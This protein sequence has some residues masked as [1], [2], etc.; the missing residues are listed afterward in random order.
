MAELGSRWA[1]DIEY[2]PAG[3][4][5]MGAVFRR[6]SAACE[7]L[8]FAVDGET[9][10]V[11]THA[12]PIKA[13]AVW[14][15]GGTADMMMRLRVSLASVTVIDRGPGGLLLSSFNDVRHLVD[16]PASAPTMV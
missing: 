3:G 12:T 9:V 16:P 8:R 5:S 14:A 13:A 2:E 11:V 15:L 1:A 4:E 6:V 10:L 7:E